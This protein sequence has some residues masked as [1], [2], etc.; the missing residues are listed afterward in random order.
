M[1]HDKQYSEEQC[2][3]WSPLALEG[4]NH[5]YSKVARRIRESTLNG[6]YCP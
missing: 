2:L 5:G 6:I 4:F 3:Q 1:N